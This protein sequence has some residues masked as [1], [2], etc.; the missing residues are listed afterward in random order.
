MNRSTSSSELLTR[1]PVA[2]TPRIALAPSEPVAGPG[3]RRRPGSEAA[4][5][6][7]GVEHEQGEPGEDRD[8]DPCDEIMQA[9]A[10]EEGEQA[11]GDPKADERVQQEQGVSGRTFRS[12]P[13]KIQVRPNT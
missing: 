11:N 3:N 2:A 7:H 8:D 1:P 9:G 5:I 12:V 4:E 13:R 6:E 10:D